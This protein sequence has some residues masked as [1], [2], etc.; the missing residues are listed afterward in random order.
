MSVNTWNPVGAST[1]MNAVANWSLGVLS[2]T[3]DLVFDNTK[4]NNATATANMPSV[5]TITVAA[6][7]AGVFNSNGKSIT[8]TGD[9]T[10]NSGSSQCQN[11]TWTIGRDLLIGTGSTPTFSNATM[12]VRNIVSAGTGGCAGTMTSCTISGDL[13]VSATTSLV[14]ALSGAIV[15]SGTPT[16]TIGK[17]LQFTWAS[18]SPCSVTF[19]HGATFVQTGTLTIYRMV[20]APGNTYTWTAGATFTISAFTA[21]DWNGT[22]GHLVTFVSSVPGTSYTMSFTVVVTASYISVTDCTTVST[23][24]N[25]LPLVNDG[26]SVRGTRVF[27]WQW[28]AAQFIR[29]NG[30]NGSGWSSTQTGLS[31]AEFQGCYGFQKAIDTYGLGDTISAYG[32]I[33]LNRLVLLTT[34]DKSSTWLVGHAVAENV[35]S[36]TWAGVL[37]EITTST[38]RI[39][40]STGTYTTITI[41]NGIK[42][43]TITDTTTCSAKAYSSIT[44]DT[45]TGLQSAGINYQGVNSSYVAD[46]T[47]FII[48]GN[49]VTIPVAAI[50]SKEYL[51]FK[52]FTFQNS[53]TYCLYLSSLDSGFYFYHCKFLSATANHGIYNTGLSRSQF[54]ECIIANNTQYGIREDVVSYN[55][56]LRCQITGNGQYGLLIYCA[57]V[58]N[59]I[60]AN[61]TRHA[62][63]CAAT[64]SIYTLIIGNIIY[65]TSGATYS[66]IYIESLSGRAYCQIMFNI[67]ESNVTYGINVQYF[68]CLTFSDYNYFYGNGNS[69][70]NLNLTEGS[71]SVIGTSSAM[72]NAAGGNYTL[73]R[74]FPYRRV[75]IPID[76][77]NATPLINMYA[78]MGIPDNDTR[79]NLTVNVT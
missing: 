10:F 52:Y 33:N 42:N 1:D 77:Q 24:S 13:T 71:N 25:F 53:S 69:N 59:C 61:N 20:F 47:Q 49:T 68:N 8:T 5:A 54:I 27:G 35:V 66:G 57:F 70:A 7:Y 18:Y 65:N 22:S 32:T 12:T 15:F 41:A 28:D 19:Q 73:K 76:W 36:P 38:M 44:F 4:A 14:Y 40:L 75:K 21:G 74:T 17:S 72:I 46:G 63:Y 51:F 45:N 50:S 48:D 37:C 67:I 29:V 56:F 11:S 62:I 6:N 60:F 2:A 58:I 78:T 3:D 79:R 9:V 64:S 31:G 34:P 55:L 16:I 39:E 23:I 43:T 26:T 30:N